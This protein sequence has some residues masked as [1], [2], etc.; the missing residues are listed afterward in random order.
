MILN[1]HDFRRQ[2]ELKTLPE[3]YFDHLGHLRIAWIYLTSGELELAIKKITQ[4]IKRYA[5]SLGAKDKFNYTL[6]EATVR[7]MHYH[8]QDS[9]QTSFNAFI[10]DNP[11][12]VTNLPAILAYH[13]SQKRLMC[14]LAKQSFV[15]PDLKPFKHPSSI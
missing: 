4:G 15:E 1:D 13:Y 7:V 12:L 3:K 8:I 6:T 14:S 2:F 10:Q 5:E 9:P 11:Q